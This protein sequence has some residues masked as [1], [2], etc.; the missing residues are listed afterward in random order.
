MKFHHRSG[1]GLS[2]NL[3]NRVNRSNGR[4]AFALCQLTKTLQQFPF[5]HLSPKLKNT[6]T[7]YLVKMFGKYDVIITVQNPCLENP[8]VSQ[9]KFRPPIKF[10]LKWFVGE[11][12]EDF[13]SSRRAFFFPSFLF[14]QPPAEWVSSFDFLSLF[15]SH[16]LF[17]FSRCL[18]VPRGALQ[19]EAVRCFED[20]VSSSLLGI[21]QPPCHSP[22]SSSHSPW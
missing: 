9:A 12:L 8:K 13:V 22:C 18:Q 15:C 16:S 1:S 6:N 4:R 19:E 5:F 14:P 20:F 2:K 7:P 3:D 21:P 17:F 11:N 10:G